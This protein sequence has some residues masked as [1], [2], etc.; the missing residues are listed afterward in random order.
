M[1]SAQLQ[2]IERIHNSEYKRSGP[3]SY[4]YLLHKYNFCPTM[5]GPY[6]MASK[7][8]DPK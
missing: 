2:R 3:K 7:V 4:V 5:E 6:F 1:A 8:Q